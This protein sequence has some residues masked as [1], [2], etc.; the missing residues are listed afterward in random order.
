YK[1]KPSEY[2]SHLIGH[3]GEGSVLSLVRHKRWATGVC[4]GVSGSGYNSSS[5]CATFS[6]TFYLTKAGVRHWLD[7]A[8]VLFRYIGML[9]GK[10]PQE[11]VFNEIR[12]VANI[13]YK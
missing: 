6:V 13:Q 3:E 8:D 2:L 9:K 12:D 4:A 5:C 7:I 11:W 10:G 1:K